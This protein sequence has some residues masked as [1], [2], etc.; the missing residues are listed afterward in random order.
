MERLERLKQKARELPEDSGVYLMRSKKKEINYVG[1]AKVLKNRVSSY[2]RSL[3]KHTPKVFKMV[4]HIW[5]FDVIVTSSEF[6][7]L[8]L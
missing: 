8:V 2:F 4:E 7:A 3:E 5:D 6:E 1:K